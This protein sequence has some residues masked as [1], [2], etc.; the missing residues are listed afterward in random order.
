MENYVRYQLMKKPKWA[1]PAKIFGFVWSILYLIIVITYGLV[2]YEVFLGNIPIVVLLPFVL[3]LLFNLIF[4]PIQFGLKNNVLALLDILLVLLTLVWLMNAILP[5]FPIVAYANIPHLLW[6]L[7]ATVLQAT[8][9][10]LNWKQ[11]LRS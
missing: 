8:I 10:S 3:N 1:P 11:P 7:F 5:Y 6:V 9:T 4:T 2:A